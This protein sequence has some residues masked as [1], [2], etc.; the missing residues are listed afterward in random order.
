M[1]PVRR[2][3][4]ALILHAILLVATLITVA[5]FAFTVATSFKLQ[6]DIGAGAWVFTPIIDNY[7]ALFGGDSSLSRL[8]VNSALVAAMATIATIAVGGLAA[9]A[10]A[11]YHWPAWVTRGALGWLIFVHM[12]PPVT[13]IFPLYS[14]VRELG[15]YDTVFGVALGHIAL[16]LPL[17]V[18]I[19]LDFFRSIPREI[20][21]AAAVDG[22]DRFAT[23]WRVTLPLAWSGIA[24]A[25]ILTFIFSWREF[26]FALSVTST[27]A[28]M[29]LPVGI[30]G[31]AQ[32]NSVLY[33]QM[34]AATTVAAI[35]AIVAIVIA[36]RRIVGGLTLGAVTG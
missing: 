17:T 23:F 2:R 15:I 8:I 28:A 25:S 24:A 14:I 12:M 31:F 19:L 33:G 22:A 9:H 30:A 21:D 4:D 27:N 20:E 5:P 34:A 7:A 13:F 11:R 3:R 29:T 18:F 16:L 1:T 32:E 35:P 6:R 36:Q 26:A 10:L